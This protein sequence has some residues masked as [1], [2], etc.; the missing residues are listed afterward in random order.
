M[1]SYEELQK[2]KFKFYEVG[3]TDYSDSLIKI[4]SQKEKKISFFKRGFGNKNKIFRR[5]VYFISKNEELKFYKE[6]LNEFSLNNNL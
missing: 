3:L 6:K 5:W 4:I 2:R 1:L